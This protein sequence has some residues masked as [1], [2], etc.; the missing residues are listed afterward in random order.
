MLRSSTRRQRPKPSGLAGRFWWSRSAAAPL[1]RSEAGG[2]GRLMDAHRV[3]SMHHGQRGAD[4]R[5]F[6]SWWKTALVKQSALSAARRNDR[7]DTK[8]FTRVSPDFKP[9]GV[10]AAEILNVRGAGSAGGKTRGTTHKSGVSHIPAKSSP[11]NSFAP[12]P[13]RRGC[14]GAAGPRRRPANRRPVLRRSDAG[15]RRRDRLHGRGSQ[16]R[17]LYVPIP[18]DP[19]SAPLRPARRLSRARSGRLVDRA[20]QR[21][22]GDR[23]VLLLG[24]GASV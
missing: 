11:P 13:W 17:G 23:R 5:S 12:P 20:V 21:G 15:G 16:Q 3:R 6:Y 10:P 2:A 9:G 7:S 14:C 1:R 19:R 4:W 22:P 18:W 8:R 24:H